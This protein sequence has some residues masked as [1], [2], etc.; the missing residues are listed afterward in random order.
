MSDKK[1]QHEFDEYFE[2]ANLP[3][4]ITAD[5]K[6]QVRTKKRG[7]F[8]KWLAPAVLAAVLLSVGILAVYMNFSPVFQSANNPNSADHPDYIF[9]SS[10]PL[11]EAPID[12]YSADDIKGLDFAKKLAVSKYTTVR[13]S[14]FSDGSDLKYAQATA[15]MIQNGFRYDAVIY[16]E[17]TEEYVCLDELQS[18]LSGTERI[19]NGCSCIFNTSYDRGENVYKIYFIK[20]GVKYYISVMTS[21]N[22]NNLAKF[23]KIF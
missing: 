1:L 12:P 4:N 7:G 17:Y 15:S 22:E 11:T 5:A 16:T 10:A 8:L 6:A 14:G 21:D 18:F 3:E 9:Y 19:M 2:G 23:L 20:N 13:L